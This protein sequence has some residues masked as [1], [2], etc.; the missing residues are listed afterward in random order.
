[1]Y[2]YLIFLKKLAQTLIFRAVK[3]SPA[4]RWTIL[5]GLK[6]KLLS[7]FGSS[8]DHAQNRDYAPLNQ[9]LK[10]VLAVLFCRMGLV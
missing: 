9:N 2:S 4:T 5:I 3:L 10:T 1:M 7:D 8:V 6:T